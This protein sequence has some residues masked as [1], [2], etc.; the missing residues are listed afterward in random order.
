[1]LTYIMKKLSC[2][3]A[4]AVGLLA[5]PAPSFARQHPLNRGHHL[6]SMVTGSDTVAAEESLQNNAPSTTHIPDLPRFAVFGKDGKFYLGIGGSVKVTAGYDFGSPIPNANEFVT[7]DI[8]MNPTPGQGGKFNLSAQQ[9]NLFV[10]FVALPGTKNELGAYV[11]MN[12]LGNNYTPSLQFAYLK[13][14]GITAGYDFSLFSD[15]AAAPP[16]IDYEGPN[17]L[18]TFPTAVANYRHDFG[19]NKEWSAGAGIELPQTSATY[20]GQTSKMSQRVPD[21]PAYVQYSWMKGAGW[22]RLSGMVRNMFYYDNA[23]GK[24]HDKVGWGI[25]L[26][27]STPIYGGLRAYYHGIFGKG[28]TSYMQDLTGMGMDMMP[29][30]GDPTRLHAVKSWGAY[31]GLQ[32]TFSPKVYC[33]ATYSHVRTYVPEYNGGSSAWSGQYKYAQYVVANVFWNITP[34]VQTGVEYIYGR[35]MDYS[36]M[37]Q[38]D[39]RIQT[40]LQVSF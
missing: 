34:I 7:S 38:H 17:S 5:I 23:A 35:R 9:S 20:G 8:P 15:A 27:G 33:S 24:G 12:F 37:Q 39:N 11:A 10:N 22:I 13:Y 6:S 36:G 19:K 40:M 31:G 14:R 2:V 4:I 3:A 29:V 18:A 32:Y 26:S 28:I 16:T 25:G 21:I 1:M 30:N